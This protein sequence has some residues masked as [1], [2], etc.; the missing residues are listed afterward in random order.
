MVFF[1][2]FHIVYNENKRR[3]KQK[4]WSVRKMNLSKIHHI[5]IIVS[6]YEAAK[7]FYEIGRASWRERV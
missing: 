7:D 3:T 2:G 4:K 1:E 6:D 5:A